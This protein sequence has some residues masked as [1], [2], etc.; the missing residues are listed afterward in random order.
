MLFPIS[1]IV[2]FSQS[3]YNDYAE[4]VK[5]S[6]INED[7]N[8]NSIKWT[9][10]NSSDNSADFKIKNGYFQIIVPDKN[11]IGL[12][13]IPALDLNQNQNWEIETRI[14]YSGGSAFKAFALIWGYKDVNSQGYFF[15]IDP[16]GLFKIQKKDTPGSNFISYKDWAP[17]RYV[18]KSDWNKLTV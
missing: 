16:R 11:N 14:K 18:I 15:F 9:L 13:C 2:S 8:N 4:N 6:V 3:N 5:K 12:Q 1:A 17:A 7:F 10:D